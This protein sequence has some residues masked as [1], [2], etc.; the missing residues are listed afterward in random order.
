MRHDLEESHWNRVTVSGWLIEN[1]Q[2]MHAT[3]C[4]AHSGDNMG[5]PQPLLHVMLVA[6]G[7]GSALDIAR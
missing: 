2:P 7:F 1:I 4:Q 5:I 6:I 3:Q